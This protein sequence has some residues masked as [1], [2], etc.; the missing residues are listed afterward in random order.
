M[1]PQMPRFAP[2]PMSTPAVSP[3]AG[4][5]GRPVAQVNSEQCMGCGRCTTVCPTG[6]ISLGVDGKATVSA[7]L[8]QG[9]AACVAQC[10]AQA[11][12]LA[13]PVLAKRG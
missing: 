9:C 8:C 6:A 3:G 13:M 10:P 12:S 2:A 5:V 11:I 7:A 4:G 1:R